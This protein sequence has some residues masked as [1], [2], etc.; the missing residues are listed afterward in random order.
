MECD[1]ICGERPGPRDETNRGDRLGGR[2]GGAVSGEPEPHLGSQCEGRHP[3]AP[4]ARPFQ[5]QVYCNTEVSCR[6]PL[7]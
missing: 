7:F 3:W 4:Y 6:V 5:L 2:V 1:V